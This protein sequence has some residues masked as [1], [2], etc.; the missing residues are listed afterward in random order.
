MWKTKEAKLDSWAPHLSESLDWGLR[1][2]RQLR[3]WA[4]IKIEAVSV[5]RKDNSPKPKHNRPRELYSIISRNTSC[6]ECWRVAR[7]LFLD[8]RR[9]CTRIWSAWTG[10]ETFP[11][12]WRQAD[13]RSVPVYHRV[14]I[15]VHVWLWSIIT[16][17]RT[18]D[19]C[20]DTTTICTW[21]NAVAVNQTLRC[22]MAMEIVDAARVLQISN[23]NFE[24][25]VIGAQLIYFILHTI[26]IFSWRYLFHPN[27][28]HRVS[29]KPS[30]NRFAFGILAP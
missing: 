5:E 29:E 24:V 4:S 17:V 27:V 12:R 30:N 25:K 21:R 1:F 10:R 15:S 23:A 3:L 14:L 26:H 9:R 11:P 2:E 18:S 8:K 16:C 6:C 19:T 13:F 28:P 7:S 20:L 22:K